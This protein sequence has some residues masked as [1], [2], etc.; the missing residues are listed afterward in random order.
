[1]VEGA[2][3]PREGI[4]LEG[5][6]SMAPDRAITTFTQLEGPL[7][8][9]QRSVQLKA[10]GDDRFTVR[11]VVEFSV[12]LPWWSWLL[13]LPLRFSLGNAVPKRQ[14]GAGS[15]Q[16]P[17]WAPPQRLDRRQAVVIA[18]LAALVCVQGYLA[19]LL[20]E[21]LTYAASEMDVGTFGQGVVFAA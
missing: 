7:A 1:A 13:A 16:M 12:G 11:H 15:R 8:S 5:V 6:A 9:Y 4:V 3:S 20:P 19:A 17:W 10:L 21:T 18:A 14:G 2:L